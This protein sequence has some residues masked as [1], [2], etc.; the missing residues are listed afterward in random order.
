MP[1]DDSAKC[2]PTTDYEIDSGSIAMYALA[3]VAA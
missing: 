1:R 2:V 3:R